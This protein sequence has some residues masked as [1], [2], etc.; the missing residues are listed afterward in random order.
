VPAKNF[1]LLLAAFA[2]LRAQRPAR[3]LILGEGRE[4][5]RLEAA[6]HELGID[7]DVAL[8]GHVDNPY[9]AF[10]RASLFVLSSDWEGLPTVLIEALACGCPVVSTDCPSGPAEILERGRYG[11]LVPVGDAVALAHA[12]ARTLDQPP[13]PETLR[14]RSEAFTLERS[15]GRY[16]DLL[17]GLCNAHG[18]S[19]F[20]EQSQRG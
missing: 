3:L 8:P 11:S 12:M 6:A 2:R 17:D 9:A 5:L 16:L 19:G 13:A 7:A 15:A 1:S 20:V 10:S 4:R 14:L 18:S